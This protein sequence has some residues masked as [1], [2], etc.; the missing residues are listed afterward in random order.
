MTHLLGLHP[1]AMRHVL[2]L[3]FPG[4]LGWKSHGG[5]HPVPNGWLFARIQCPF[6]WQPFFSYLYLSLWYFP[7]TSTGHDFPT[8]VKVVEVGPRDGL[9]NEKVC[10]HF[11]HECHL[12]APLLCIWDMQHPIILLVCHNQQEHVFHIFLAGGMTGHLAYRAACHCLIPSAQHIALQRQFNMWI[13][14]SNE[15]DSYCCENNV[16]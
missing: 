13:P 14:N 4:Q 9:Q 11:T 2:V 8:F 1:R 5:Q 6:D 16:C 12:C 10:L 3:R 7:Q 15:T